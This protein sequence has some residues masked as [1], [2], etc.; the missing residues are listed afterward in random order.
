MRPAT[1]HRRI[2]TASERGRETHAPGLWR[3]V[4]FAAALGGLAGCTADTDAGPSP[5]TT[6]AGEPQASSSA[7]A[8]A[9]TPVEKPQRPAAMDREDAKG[10]AAAAEYF[11]ELYPY[12]MATGDTAEFEAMSHEACRACS[13]ALR[14]A[15]E[16]AKNDDSYVNGGVAV[17]TREVYEQDAL[18]GIFPVDVHAETQAAKII[19]SSGD[20]VFSEPAQ[21]VDRRVEVAIRDGKWVVAGIS[22]GPER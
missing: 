18:T 9:R 17:E 22:E 3:C 7:S 4:A 13:D 2:R 12:I 14:Q 8:S 1:E 19:T 16:I 5:T 10:A 15:D 20:E 21:S 11:I 6:V